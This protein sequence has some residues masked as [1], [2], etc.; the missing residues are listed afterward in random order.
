MSTQTNL[1]DWQFG[2][3]R[4]EPSIEEPDEATSDCR[5]DKSWTVNGVCARCQDNGPRDAYD[6]LLEA[7]G[8]RSTRNVG[9]DR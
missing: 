7:S 3:D 2:E 5:H 6:G 1:G 9:G 8:G 4:N